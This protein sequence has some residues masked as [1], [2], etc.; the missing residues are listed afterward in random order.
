MYTTLNEQECYYSWSNTNSFG[1]KQEVVFCNEHGFVKHGE[2]RDT[3]TEYPSTGAIAEIKSILTP[4]PA[5]CEREDGEKYPKKMI[6]DITRRESATESNPNVHSLRPGGA[7]RAAIDSTGSYFVI[8]CPRKTNGIPKRFLYYRSHEVAEYLAN[9][10]K[11]ETV[12]LN[13][14]RFIGEK[15]QTHSFVELEKMKHLELT[16]EQ[17]MARVK[18]H[19]KLGDEAK[20]ALKDYSYK[21]WKSTLRVVKNFLVSDRSIYKQDDFRLSFLLDDRGEEFSY[22]L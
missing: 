10:V 17:F 6:F 14:G 4:R 2:I 16:R 12:Q 22:L 8:V 19:V 21:L 7:F 20:N 9:S 15:F 13:G 5:I 11:S 3:D 18:N 1:K